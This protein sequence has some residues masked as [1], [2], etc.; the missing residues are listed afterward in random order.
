L[1]AR[2]VDFWLWVKKI[3]QPSFLNQSEENF[4]SAAKGE[5]SGKADE[6]IRASLAKDKVFDINCIHELAKYKSKC[7]DL[8]EH[9]RI[10]TGEL[11]YCSNVIAAFKRATDKL[12]SSEILMVHQL[13]NVVAG[14]DPQGMTKKVNSETNLAPVDSQFGS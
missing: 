10:L 6:K 14:Q 1:G 11:E 9:V 13:A 4:R 5:A 7:R 8:V 2:Q 3:I 12:F